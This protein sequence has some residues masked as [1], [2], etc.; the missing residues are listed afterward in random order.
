MHVQIYLIVGTAIGSKSSI[1]LGSMGTHTLPET[2]KMVYIL[3]KD[4]KTPFTN[5]FLNLNL[6]NIF[7]NLK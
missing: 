6:V 1:F 5:F 2:H 3:N 4:I 7:A